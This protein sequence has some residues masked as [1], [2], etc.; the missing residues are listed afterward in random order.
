MLRLTSI[1][2]LLMTA[3][4]STAQAQWQRD[5]IPIGQRYVGFN[6]DRDVISV[7][8]SDD[9]YRERPLRAFVFLV[10]R[11]DIEINEIRLT[12]QNGFTEDF[13]IG[14]IIRGGGQFEL[15]L[16]GERSY[17][18]EI[19]MRYRSN[20]D[21]RRQAI[22]S[23]Y[24]IPARRFDRDR[25]GFGSGPGAGPGFAGPGGPRP[26]EWV[27]LGCQ[28]VNLTR[29]RDEIRVGRRDGRFRAIRLAVRDADIEI[30]ILRVVYLNGRPDDLP[31][32]SMIRAGDRSR[33]LDLQG[34]D[35][36]IDRIEMVYRTVINPAQIISRGQLRTATVCAEGL[37]NL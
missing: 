35:R 34:T 31:V 21:S 6:A 2:A 29:D 22:V 20:P 4:I 9:F 12:Y 15:D 16:R 30:Q 8:Q 3:L 24:G 13:R 7:V 27:E 14:Q 32:Q 17:I 36:G 11:N 19:E 18:K 5:W 28:S 25:P 1:I 37:Q 33:P 23:V 10:D 26:P